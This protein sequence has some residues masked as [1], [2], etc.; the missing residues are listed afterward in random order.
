MVTLFLMFIDT[1]SSD[2]HNDKKV[3]KVDDCPRADKKVRRWHK[4]SPQ[5]NDADGQQ[6]TQ[7]VFGSPYSTYL[8]WCEMV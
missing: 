1:V 8:Q 4:V 2:A 6:L 7:F 3:S 5:S